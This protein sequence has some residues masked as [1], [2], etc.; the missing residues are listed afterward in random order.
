MIYEKIDK[1]CCMWC[2]SP[3]TETHHLIRRSLE[4][5]F[6]NEP[7]NLINLCSA[8]HRLCTES[9]QVETMF[10]YYFFNK[11]EEKVITLKRI[12]ET[13]ELNRIISPRELAEY[14]MYLASCYA[15]LNERY[16]CLIDVETAVWGQIRA[17]EGITSDKQADKEWEKTPEGLEMRKMK[18]D[19]KTVEKLMSAIKQAQYQQRVEAKNQ[20]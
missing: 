2:A 20:Y 1:G 16:K 17:K 14:H 5:K 13:V 9:K 3:A 12:I 6:I 4:P 8:C 7:A 15:K 10:Q 11:K 18:Y 19:F